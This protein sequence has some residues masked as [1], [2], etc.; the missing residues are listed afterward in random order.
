MKPRTIL[1]G[2]ALALALAPATALADTETTDLVLATDDCTAGPFR[3]AYGPG[4]KTGCNPRAIDHWMQTERFTDFPAVN[5]L[6][7]T[8]DTAR[9]IHVEVSVG[10]YTGTPGVGFGPEKVT[11]TLTGKKQGSSTTQALGTATTTGAAQDRLTNATMLYK[12]DLAPPADKAGVY[13][14]LNLA[15]SVS[16]SVLS[17][18]TDFDGPTFVSFPIID[19]TAP[20]EEEEE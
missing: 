15:L 9:K 8:L 20:V 7:L 2:L 3:M 6:P 14:E 13:K 16:G 18:Y 5:G 1:A 19:G 11:V 4:A 17:G 12:F 10:N